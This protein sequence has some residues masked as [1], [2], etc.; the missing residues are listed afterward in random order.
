MSRLL[1]NAVWL[2]ALGVLVAGCTESKTRYVTADPTASGVNSGTT[3]PATSVTFEVTIE[4]VSEHTF[5]PSPVS[6]GVWAVHGP[7][8][9]LFQTGAS[10][11]LGIEQVAEDG[12]I[13]TLEAEAAALARSSG[14]FA[15]LPPGAI[16][17]FQFTASPD[18]GSLSLVTM[19]GHS[20]DLFL[21]PGANGIALFDANG[22]PISGDLSSQ[23]QLWDAGTEINEV[24]GMGI[25]A[26]MRQAAPN[27]GA[28][29]GV[30]RAY[31]HATR[32]LPQGGALVEALVSEAAGS[33][34][35]RLKNVAVERGAF[36]TA[37]SRAFYAL[38]DGRFHILTM[39]D[40]APRNGLE[41]LA[42]DGNPNELERHAWANRG[43]I[44]AG[45]TLAI[46]PGAEGALTVQPR[47]AHTRL[48]IATMVVESNDAFVTAEAELLDSNGNPRSA[49]EVQRELNKNLVLWD[50]GTEANQVPGAGTTQPLRQAVANTGPADPNPKVRRYDDATNDF[51]AQH[52]PAYLSVSVA[53]RGSSF[54]VTVTNTSRT[55]ALDGGL[56]PLTWAL[57]S[58]GLRLADEGLPATT[59]IERLAEDG[60][61]QDLIAD[62][63]QRAGVSSTGVVNVA[64]GTNTPGPIHDGQS[65]VVD[66]RPDAVNRFLSL[67]TMP[68]P[69]NDTIITV[70]QGGVAL[71]DLNGNYRS[72][73]AINAD[74]AKLLA[75]QDAG[76]EANET[77]AAGPHMPPLQPGPNTGRSEGTGRVRVYDDATWHYPAAQG[78]LKITI[79]A[80]GATATTGTSS[81]PLAGTT[82]P[83]TTPQPPVTPTPTP[84]PSGTPSYVNDI[85]PILLAPPGA[86]KSSCVVCHGPTSQRMFK[87]S[88]N[89][90]DNDADRQ[91]VVGLTNAANPE[92]SLVIQKPSAQ[93]NHL[94]GALIPR[95]TP[96]YDTLLRW[97]AAG[98]PR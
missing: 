87:L 19:L 89:L 14:S 56:S 30:V 80:L 16:T 58:G 57:H 93:V 51:D 12:Q 3:A 8:T 37:L 92:A 84:A 86:S 90:S 7:Q 4:N 28:A 73:A 72:N 13:M 1:S 53:R 50:A 18:A 22:T 44:D 69:T 59:G 83:S 54:R 36:T 25:D 49:A 52:L 96:Q 29:E 32:A 33:Y 71:L 39:G 70:D 15:G 21:A 75:A 95:G 24:P 17:T 45:S 40:P 77:G 10:A 68:Y 42:E 38:H 88:A 6:P 91:A 11:S 31:R 27:T 64:N 47:G 97:I 48:V 20:N 43:V 23:L 41:Q 61:T 81:T 67:V 74:I 46:P 82:P 63:S 2:I 79:K 65:Y 76:T 62:L 55:G 60:D 26:G 66:V 94:G 34:T 85:R 9:G 35:I 5:L 78:L 98:S